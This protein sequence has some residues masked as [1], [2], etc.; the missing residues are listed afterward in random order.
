[1]ARYA[2]VIGI[3]TNLSPLVSLSKNGEYAAAIAD[4]LEKYGGFDKILRLIGEVAKEAIE[5]TLVS[6]LEELAIG[7]DA[8]IFLVGQTVSLSGSFGKRRVYL[9][10][11]DCQITVRDGRVVS[12]DGGILLEDLND[13]I[14]SADLSSL[15][16]VLDLSNS[17]EVLENLRL[18]DMM[19]AFSKPDHVL[20]AACQNF[21][22]PDIEVPASDKLFATVLLKGLKEV[23]N[24][25][26]QVT[27]KDLFDF[28]HKEIEGQGESQKP[29]CIGSGR[30]IELLQY[31][32]EEPEPDVLESNGIA[33]PP[34]GIELRCTFTGHT[35][36]ISE[37]A[38]SA[39]GKNLA[40]S[41]RDRGV[42]IWDLKTGRQLD[43]FAGSGKSGAVSS[44]AWSTDGKTLL[45]S[46]N[47]K[48]IRVWNVKTQKS[49][50]RAG[51]AGAINSVSF[52]P[53]GEIYASGS[54]DKTVRVYTSSNG[55][56][57]FA[58]KGHVGAILSIAWSP[59]DRMLASSSSDKTVKI[60]DCGNGN[61]IQTFHGHT[62]EVLSVAWSPDGETIVSSSKDCTI[63]IWS[64][65]KKRRS[66]LEGHTSEVVSVSFSYDGK[67]LASKANDGWIKLWRCD[68]WK[69]I[70]DIDEP[71][72]TGWQSSIAF[73]P[74]EPVLATLGEKD[75]IIRIWDLDIDALLAAEPTVETMKYTNAKVVLLGDTSVGKS[76]LRLV[77]TGNPFSATDSTHGRYVETFYSENVQ[78]ETGLTELR[79]VVLWDLAGQPSYRLIHQLHLNEVAIA[80]IIVDSRSETDP[81][82]GVYH[83]NRALSQAQTVQ[84]GS[85]IPLKKFLVAARIDRGGIGVSRERIEK[86][87]EELGL[88][89]YF[90]TSAKEGIGITELKQAILDSIDWNSMSEVN[91]TALFQETKG[92]LITQKRDGRLLSSV[93]DLYYQFI[94]THGMA[95]EP[96]NLYAQFETCIKLLESRGVLRKL[97]FGSLVLLQPELIDAYA[98]AIV[99]AAKDSPEGIGSISESNAR[100][101]N[102]PMSEDERAKDKENE[103]LLLL[104]T[105]EDL[106]SHEIALRDQDDLV[107][108]SQ[109]TREYPHTANMEGKSVTFTFEG[110][111]QN[112]YSKLIVRLSRS[113]VFTAGDMWK[114]AALFP[115]NVGGTCGVL[116][117]LI[118]D[119]KAE[120][121]L[122]FDSDA[123]EETCFNFESYIGNYLQ[124]QSLRDSV[125]RRRIFTC[126][127]CQTNIPDKTV[128]L[129]RQR[130]YKTITCSVCDT[131]FSI[132][133]REERL[134]PNMTGNAASSNQDELGENLPAFNIDDNAEKQ[135]K[136]ETDTTIL[137][138]KIAIGDFDVF[139]AHN[140]QDKPQ[141]EAIAN[142]LRQRG[143]NPWID[144]EQIAPGQWVQDAIQDTIVS[145]VKCAAV[146]IGAHG[147]GQWQ[148]IEL[149]TFIQQCVEGNLS[150]IPVLLPGVDEI[151]E[152]LPFLKTMNWV[153]FEE[154][155]NDSESLDRL[156][157]GITG[158]HPQQVSKAPTSQSIKSPQRPLWRL[159][160]NKLPT[161]QNS[162]IEVFIS[163]SSKDQKLRQEL[164]IHLSNLKRQGTIVA[165]HDR[166]I[167]AGEEWETQIKS[168]LESA[169]IILL[170]ISPDFMAS[171][172][173]YDLEM[174]RAI[175]RH[176][177][178][179]AQVIPIL[180]RP[181]DWIETPFSG[182][183]VLPDGR[184]P[185]TTAVNQDEA[186]VNVVQGI[187]RSIDA[188]TH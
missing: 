118:E 183:Q 134:K 169:R 102:F 22:R 73:H 58:L 40:S 37:I 187:R 120:L 94:K 59:N 39:D 162:Q 85:T 106:L 74:K 98:S 145:Q 32:L 149:R 152:T 158:K 144:T 136:Q 35:D 27:T 68:N 121:V 52:S 84:E 51:H 156:E 90:E 19:T 166:K 91:S 61:L 13:L 7:N 42:R 153:R 180:L 116:L 117:K 45:S 10:P 154:N 6:F 83:W 34:P 44:L 131:V 142:A 76:G 14:Q 89:G 104:A 75:C 184:T 2:I 160:G 150:V 48:S 163:Y 167:E 107:F 31:P 173:C 138:G 38:W 4:L 168:H 69:T 30:S 137:Q 23:K 12:Q 17:G 165:W 50:S 157:W 133:D 100:S 80:L 105:V 135:R 1:M 147:I 11:S 109:F 175:Q 63:R 159:E 25:Q 103:K 101:G 99:N 77:L 171:D 111:I 26:G 123:S 43:H 20:M 161:T 132:L 140:S 82:A 53:D 95:R 119:G 110:A 49:S 71:S 176:Q 148:A 54:S 97:S 86:L 21:G 15:V 155:V 172:Y 9:A 87:Q 170:L 56:F 29:I 139:L 143:I 130:G 112:I 46:S 185:I 179:S 3:A 115:A 92:F 96:E 126:P 181:T 174:R 55:K 88:D 81:F 28:I 57:N 66:I 33:D 67:L 125:T 128:Q 177:N 124:R 70:K 93:D 114:N 108:P 18:R 64:L 146:F 8:L 127:D 129:R 65:D 182:L 41:S 79:E 60:W 36:L 62:D 5:Q 24:A 141:M 178:G 122:F 47:A 188:L 72:C 16:T 186:F 113:M 164:E 78:T 151:P